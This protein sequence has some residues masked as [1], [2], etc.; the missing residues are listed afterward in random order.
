LLIAFSSNAKPLLPPT[1]HRFYM[2]A[3]AK[4]VQL[5][6]TSLE[7]KR[8]FLQFA[9]HPRS[10][11]RSC[12]APPTLQSVAVKREPPQAQDED[13][14]LRLGPTLQSVAVKREPPQAQDVDAILRL[15]RA[16]TLRETWQHIATQLCEAKTC[17]AKADIEAR[18]MKLR[19][20]LTLGG[21]A[22]L[23]MLIGLSHNDL[24]PL[25]HQ[26]IIRVCERVE[27]VEIWCSDRQRRQEHLKAL[28]SE[29]PG[30][31]ILCETSL[32]LV[33]PQITAVLVVFYDEGLKL[34]ALRQ[35]VLEMRG[36]PPERRVALE[37]MDGAK[38]SGKTLRAA[39]LRRGG[40]VRALF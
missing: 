6:G 9:V 2:S 31:Q 23:K 26:R 28:I 34:S 5:F 35:K 13:A 38:V 37:H 14:I 40:S 27:R 32:F 29:A 15:G 33:L 12:S 24:M 39:G 19:A 22:Q 30:F 1:L 8:T 3:A 25:C 16:Q 4:A 10:S 17:G 11:V 20:T 18:K 36:L 7:V 21:F